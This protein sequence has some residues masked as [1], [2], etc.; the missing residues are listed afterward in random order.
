MNDDTSSSNDSRV[1]DQPAVKADEA[2]VNSEPAKKAAAKAPR[3]KAAA[4]KAT[5]K[6]AT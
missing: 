3:K 1:A 4:K 2:T 6:K 5:A